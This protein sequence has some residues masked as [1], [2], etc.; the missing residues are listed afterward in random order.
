M[1]EGDGTA[2][3]RKSSITLLYITFHLDSLW[4]DFLNR[5]AQLLDTVRELGSK[6]LVYLETEIT[7]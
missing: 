5:D 4:I 1:C 6:S 3:E 2:T 7:T